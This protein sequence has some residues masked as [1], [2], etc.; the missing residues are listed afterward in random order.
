[1]KNIMEFDWKKTAKKVGWSV[2]FVFVS[3]VLSIVMDEP[4]LMFLI[5]LLEAG[6]NVLKHK[7]RWRSLFR[8]N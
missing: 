8:K 6:R 5:P 3:G 7:T 1:M 2:L 4:K